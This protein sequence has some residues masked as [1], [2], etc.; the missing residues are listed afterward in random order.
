MPTVVLFV[1][2]LAGSNNTGDLRQ[3]KKMDG[4]VDNNDSGNH[5]QYITVVGDGNTINTSQVNSNGANSDHHMAHIITGDT[6]TLSHEQYADKKKQGFVEITGDSNT[7]SLQQR[8][9]ANHFADINLTGD[10]HTVTGAQCGK[11]EH[12][13]SQ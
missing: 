1:L 11:V 10:D 5:E 6:N 8:N 13:T 4:N 3:G 9:G 7:V 2:A 12:T